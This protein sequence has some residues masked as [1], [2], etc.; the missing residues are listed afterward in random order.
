[1]KEGGREEGGAG[2]RKEKRKDFPKAKE[3][4]G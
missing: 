4:N 1:M 2:G 3:E